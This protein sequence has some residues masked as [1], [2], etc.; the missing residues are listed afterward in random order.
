M[1]PLLLVVK[2]P[3]PVKISRMG[4]SLAAT[5]EADLALTKASQARAGDGAWVTVVEALVWWTWVVLV[6]RVRQ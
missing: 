2:L 6:V 4:E 1:S 3:A 5:V